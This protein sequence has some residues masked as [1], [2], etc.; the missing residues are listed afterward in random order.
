[1]RDLVE[2]ELER[3]QLQGIIARVKFSNWAAPIVPVLKK[4][5]GIR[6]YGEYILTVN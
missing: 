2:K 5:G 4:D 1:M 6:I 3:L